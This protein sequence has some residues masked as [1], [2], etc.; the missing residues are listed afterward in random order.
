MKPVQMYVKRFPLIQQ[1]LLY[2]SAKS[3]HVAKRIHH[4]A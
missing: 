4:A 1:L 2:A 3:S